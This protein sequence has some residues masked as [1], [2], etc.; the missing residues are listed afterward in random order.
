[1]YTSEIHEPSYLPSKQSPRFIPERQQNISERSKEIAQKI[2]ETNDYSDL[3]P[4][5]LLQV[6]NY[7]HVMKDQ[8][9]KDGDYDSAGQCVNVINESREYISK[10]IY[11]SIQQKKIANLENQLLETTNQ[12]TENRNKWR[13]IIQTIKDRRDADLAQ[14][15]EENR[16]A[17]NLFD[18]QYQLDRPIEFQKYSQ[19]LMELQT[20]QQKY[21]LL[22]KYGIAKELKKRADKQQQIEDSQLQERYISRLN[23][24]RADLIRIQKEKLKLRRSFW[25]SE[26]KKAQTSMEEESSHFQQASSHIRASLQSL[27]TLEKH[28]LSKSQP[29]TA[30]RINLQTSA[31]QFRQRTLIN[32]VIYSHLTKQ[33]FKKS[34]HSSPQKKFS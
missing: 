27:P 12:A 17:L 19:S 11:D 1:M 15:S 9:M 10:S 22:K 28:N 31:S 20:L 8:Y 2:L 24:E 6:T 16:Y 7:L 14:I 30:R 32:N 34:N 23:H 29:I 18:Q 4:N 33:Q 25:E 3:T 21:I 13:E 26:L 5:N